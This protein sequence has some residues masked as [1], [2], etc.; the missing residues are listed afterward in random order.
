MY[1]PQSGGFENDDKK[2]NITNIFSNNRFGLNDSLE[3]G[4]SLTLGFDY[5]LRNLDDRDLLGI[6]LGQ[7]F[8]DK[9][10][11]D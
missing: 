7:I 8:R 1:S 5:K 6:S 10:D 3:G 9:E 4:Q 11:K 2:I